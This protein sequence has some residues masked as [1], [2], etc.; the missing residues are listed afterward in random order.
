MEY[1]KDYNYISKI[2]KAEISLQSQKIYLERIKKLTIELKEPLFWILKN[3][4]DSI[5]FIFKLSESDNTRKSYISAILAVFKHND[6]LKEANGFSSAYKIWLDRFKELD[7]AIEERYKLNK[8]STKQQEGYVPYKDIVKKRDE[9]ENTDIDKLLLGFY[10]YIKP[11]RADFNA[12]YIYKKT[13]TTI[14]KNE[15][16]IDMSN[17]KLILQEYKT[18]KDHNKLEIDLPN[19]LIKLLLISLKEKPRDFLFTD[20]NG[21]AYSANSYIKWANRRFLSLFKKAL[22]ITLIRHSYISS[23]DQNKLT[24]KEKEEIA[25]A[26]GHTKGMQ[27]LYRFV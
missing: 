18:Q 13:P 19:E 4:K 9:L 5:D 25:L 12:V 7:D 16:Y 26:M 20:K 6:G 14:N 27:E 17:K 11:L 21:D 23:L 8:P 10:T 2:S 22:T 24:T 15:N 1:N 3:P